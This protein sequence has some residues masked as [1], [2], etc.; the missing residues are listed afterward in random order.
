MA[1]G[2]YNPMGQAPAFEGS[3]QLKAAKKQAQAN[4]DAQIASIRQQL[5][6][7]SDMKGRVGSARSIQE[8][9]SYT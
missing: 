1:H 5:K 6:Q 3:A 4:I 2:A 7:L 9:N 8:V